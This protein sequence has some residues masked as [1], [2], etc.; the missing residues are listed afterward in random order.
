ML[1][2]GLGIAPNLTPPLEPWWPEGALYGVDFIANRFMKNGTSIAAAAAY[3]FTRASAK[4]APNSMDNWTQFPTDT[5]ALTDLGLLL[6]D[7]M[8]GPIADNS[9]AATVDG[10]VNG[11]A[12]IPTGWVFTPTTGVAWE[13]T[14][15]G[16]D[17]G[18]GLPYID[19]RLHGTNT[20]GG[21][22]FPQAR[23]WDGTSGAPYG[24]YGDT[25]SLS[26]Y[27][28]TVAATAAPSQSAVLLMRIARDPSGSYFP[29]QTFGVAGRQR[30]ALTRQ[31]GADTGDELYADFIAYQQK[32]DI[33]ETVDVTRRISGIQFETAPAPTSIM[34]SN[35][36][37]VIR[38]AD[39]FTLHLPVGTFDLTV[40]LSDAS[41]QI[42]N[43][44]SGDYVV[45]TNLGKAITSIIALPA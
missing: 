17:D 3:S 7:E 30:L 21:N 8:S 2:L 11:G 42:L 6:E 43:G 9:F 20:S 19:V 25:L 10:V 33:G 15:H 35:G 16:T 27:I 4:S 1:R 5:P 24:S 29:G 13:I 31:I 23:F 38:A 14:G 41:T 32:L 40:T 36:T 39:A 26:A 18:Y 45:P 34:L 22:G 37:P 44:I 28:D 12:T